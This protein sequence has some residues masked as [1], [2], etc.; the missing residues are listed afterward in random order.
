MIIRELGNDDAIPPITA[1]LHAAYAPL[2]KMG[3]RFLATHQDDATTLN[4]FRRGYGFV[5]EIDG[6]IVGTI[7]LCPPAT[8]SDCPYYLS[9]DVFTFGQFCVRPDYQ[10][11]GIGRQLLK[12][13]EQKAG[14]D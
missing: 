14:C 6:A 5:A 11:R 10:R 4:R 2:A 3:L 7:T 1:L 9:P 12:F 13:I 8:E